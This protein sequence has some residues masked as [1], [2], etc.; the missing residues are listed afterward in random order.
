MELDFAVLVCRGGRGRRTAA[1]S[2]SRCSSSRPSGASRSPS[3]SRC[4]GGSP[5]PPPS[6]AAGAAA[7]SP[8]RRTPRGLDCPTPSRCRVPQMAALLQ[9]PPPERRAVG[10]GDLLPF[11]GD[12]PDAASCRAAGSCAAAFL[13]T[14]G[15]RSFVASML[16]FLF[17]W[18]SY[19]VVLWS[20]C[21]P[22]FLKK[23]NYHP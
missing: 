18:C 21:F 19:K 1:S 15:N 20:C 8:W 23:K 11:A 6:T 22:F 2:S 14:G 3:T 7:A 16:L 17:F 5:P 9:I 10:D 4:C 12:L 13:V